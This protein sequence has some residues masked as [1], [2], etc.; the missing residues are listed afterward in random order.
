MKNIFDPMTLNGLQLKNRLWRS[1]TWL[2][3]AD[4]DGNLTDPIFETYRDLAAGGVAAII[5]EITTVSP[6]D[7]L[8]DGIVQFHSDRFIAQHKRFTQMIHEHDC[9]VF[10]QT[11]IVNPRYERVDEVIPLFR[12]AAIRAKAAGYDGIQLHAAHGFFLSRFIVDDHGKILGDILDAIRAELGRDFPIIAK[13]N[14]DDFTDGGLTITGCIEAC[15]VMVRHGIDAIEISGNYTSREARGSQRR[16]F[17][18]VCGN[19]QRTRRYSA[20]IGRRASFGRG[21]ESVAQQD[22]H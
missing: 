12:D 5:T 11:A 1:A 7:A 17:P 21:D 22:G 19:G 6:H 9:R 18:K 2:A 4:D 8:L 3:L 13:I 16:I 10:M 15:R 20:H 14:C